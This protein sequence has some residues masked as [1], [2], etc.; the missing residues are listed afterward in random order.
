[1][2]SK[3]IPAIDTQDEHRL[4]FLLSELQGEVETVKIGMELFYTFG[5]DI[6]PMIKEFDFK[7][8][9]D[10]KLHDIPNTVH[11]ATKTLAKN[12]VD[13]LNVHAAGGIEMMKAAAEGLKE[14]NQ[15]SLLI[16][17][18]QLTSTSQDMLNKELLI[19][20]Q[21]NDCVLHYAKNANHAGL[22]GVVC[23]PL[24]TKLIKDN[25]D[26]NFKCIT[27][28]VRPE[29]VH[30]HDQKRVLTPLEAIN[31]GADY[32]VIGRAIT[33]AISPKK[34]LHLIRESISK[35]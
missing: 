35:G 16:A 21:I 11:H 22:D 8:F 31:N 17:V 15:N 27:P 30:H 24:E 19:D 14:V 4:K 33:Q 12:G 2:K 20:Q 6:I 32:L 26:V 29:G 23:S 28:G 10:L 13:I 9:L 1:M 3:I 25:I 5:L 7:I 34:A 18:T